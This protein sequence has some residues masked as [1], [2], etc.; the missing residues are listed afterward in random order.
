MEATPATTWIDNAPAYAGRLESAKLMQLADMQPEEVV[1]ALDLRDPDAL[2]PLEIVLREH[3]RH[4]CAD[5]ADAYADI[6]AM[7]H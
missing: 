7:Q 3:L 6:K 5:L 4:A 2:T 1:T